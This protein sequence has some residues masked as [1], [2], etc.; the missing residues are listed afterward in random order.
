LVEA[1]R[2][3]IDHHLPRVPSWSDLVKA[4]RYA[5]NHWDGLIMYLDDGRLEIDTNVVERQLRPTTL[6]GSGICLSRD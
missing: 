2:T 1:L 6:I 5:V 3:W 4:M